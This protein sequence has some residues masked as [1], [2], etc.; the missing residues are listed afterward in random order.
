MAK[1]K[2]FRAEYGTSI[3]INGIWHRLGCIIEIEPD[4]SD[5]IAEIKE[6]AWKTVFTEVEE[7][8]KD[9]D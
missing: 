6:K 8:I 5:D 7:Q 3:E 2:S 4:E 1:V 9:L